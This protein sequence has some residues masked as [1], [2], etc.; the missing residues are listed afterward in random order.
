MSH[1]LVDRGF[2]E[3]YDYA[4][5]TLTKVPYDL[6]QEYDPEDTMRF[7]ALRLHEAGMINV[8]P[9]RAP[10]RG[11]RL[12]LPRRAQ[13]RA[14]GLSHVGGTGHETRGSCPAPRWSG[15]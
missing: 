5:Q 14:E 4:L 1:K 3:R 8:E 9:E 12:A 15:A 11:H 2:T 13:A 6:W 10:R 7:Y